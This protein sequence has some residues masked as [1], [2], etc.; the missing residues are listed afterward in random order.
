MALD[1]NN[2]LHE[3][4]LQLLTFLTSCYEFHTIQYKLQCFALHNLM[5]INTIFLIM[6]AYGL[7]GIAAGKHREYFFYQFD[8]PIWLGAVQTSG[9]SFMCTPGGEF[10][11]KLSPGL[12]PSQKIVAPPPICLAK[13]LLPSPGIARTYPV[14][15]PDQTRPTCCDL[16]WDSSNINR[17]PPLPHPEMTRPIG[18]RPRLILF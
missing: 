8:C 4:R 14:F 2:K 10:Q 18:H 16:L 15:V 1:N 11:K 6:H 3:L 5:M 13:I 12:S 9:M 7:R 17:S